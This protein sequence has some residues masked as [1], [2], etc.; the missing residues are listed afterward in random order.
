[1]FKEMKFRRVD[2]LWLKAI[3]CVL[4]AKSGLELTSLCL[5]LLFGKAKIPPSRRSKKRYAAATG[6]YGVI[7]RAQN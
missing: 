1:M 5:S 7:G 2:I 4:L 6:V 3:S